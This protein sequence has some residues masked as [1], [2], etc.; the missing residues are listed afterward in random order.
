MLRCPLCSQRVAWTSDDDLNRQWVTLI[1]DPEH[2]GTWSAGM[3]M[4]SGTPLGWAWQSK[5]PAMVWTDETHVRVE[6]FRCGW[7]DSV[8][9]PGG[10]EPFMVKR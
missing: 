4:Q 10:L 3:G 1:N 6:C 7:N 5:Q 2:W 9:Y 8:G